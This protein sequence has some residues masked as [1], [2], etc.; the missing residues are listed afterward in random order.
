MLNSKFNF[1]ALNFRAACI[2]KKKNISEET[3]LVFCNKSNRKKK[4]IIKGFRFEFS[5]KLIFKR[6]W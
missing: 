4:E 2:L 1:R 3:L 5:V 6:M